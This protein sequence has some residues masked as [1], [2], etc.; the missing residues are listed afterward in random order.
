MLTRV[1]ESINVGSRMQIQIVYG[2]V[3]C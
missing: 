3:L 2:C 1:V